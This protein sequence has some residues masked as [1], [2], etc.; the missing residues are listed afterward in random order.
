MKTP[1]SKLRGIQRKKALNLLEA[2]FGESHPKRLNIRVSMIED[3]SDVLICYPFWAY[4]R[5][6]NPQPNR[7]TS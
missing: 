4:D 2:S 6:S 5:P 1:R 7:V 3:V